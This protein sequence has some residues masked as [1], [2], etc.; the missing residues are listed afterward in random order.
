LVAAVSAAAPARAEEDPAVPRKGE[1][2]VTVLSGARLVPMGTFLDDQTRAGYR[3]WKT[4]V[5]PGFLLGLGY[6]PETDFHVSLQLGYGLDRIH[7]T[8]GTLQTKSFTILI[9]ADTNFFK[10][11]WITLYA[12][13]GI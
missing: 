6:T 10:R 8:P 7:M 2:T 5:S 12:G 13:G 11:S 1:A 3:P 4:F 9:G